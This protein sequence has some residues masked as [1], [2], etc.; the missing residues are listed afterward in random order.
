LYAKMDPAY[1]IEHGKIV[2]NL[3]IPHAA[4]KL[5]MGAWQVC[6]TE[7]AK[8]IGGWN[9]EIPVDGAAEFHERLRSWVAVINGDNSGEI[10]SRGIPVVTADYLI[11]GENIVRELEWT[12]P[13]SDFVETGKPESLDWRAA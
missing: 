9:T 3:S 13:L 5:H 8:A 4:P 10:V 2:Q 7:D 6:L 12:K 11:K 1:L